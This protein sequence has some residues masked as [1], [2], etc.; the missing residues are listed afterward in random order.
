MAKLTLTDVTSGFATASAINA[1]NTAIENAIEN[2]LSRDGSTPNQMNAALDM[3]GNMILNLA[4]PITVTGFNWEGPWVT[5]TSYAVGDAVEN[6]NASYI[7]IVAHTSGTFATD[8]AALKWQ[9]L[10]SAGSLPSQTGNGG[11]FLVTD[12]GTPSW[13]STPT[14]TTLAISGGGAVSLGTNVSIT[15]GTIT[16]ITDL[17]VA[18]GGTG[19]S[20]PAAARTALGVAYGP[21]FSAYAAIDQSVSTGVATRVTL[22]TEEIDTDSMFASSRFTPTVAGYYHFDGAVR[23]YSAT[24]TTV[25]AML[26]KNGGTVKSGGVQV[27]SS[28]NTAMQASVS[29]VIEMNGTTDYV[30][31]WGIVSGGTPV[32]DYNGAPNS[33]SYLCGHFLRPL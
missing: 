27:I 33:T 22:G 11:K 7:C 14:F 30:E 17:A 29:A 24:L 18:D 6:S 8:L 9:V 2:T 12:G 23:G 20:T 16:G 26:A 32:F 5:A 13:S 25:A 21:V 19:G 28:T 15:G 1:N 3:N 31:L 10:A 4:N